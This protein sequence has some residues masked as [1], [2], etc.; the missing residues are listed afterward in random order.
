MKARDIMT[1]DVISIR[2]DTTVDEIEKLLS[3]HRIGGL[4]SR[5]EE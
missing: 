2:A 5:N 3:E 4:P 1:R